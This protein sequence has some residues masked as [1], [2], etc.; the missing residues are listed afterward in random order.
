[1]KCF[2]IP[3]VHGRHNYL[4][5]FRQKLPLFPRLYFCMD[6]MIGMVKDDGLTN[7]FGSI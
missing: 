7:H 5:N 1:M 4:S 2:F 6:N 3:D